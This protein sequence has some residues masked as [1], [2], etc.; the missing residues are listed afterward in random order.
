[1]RSG[2]AFRDIPEGFSLTE[3]ENFN[4][5]IRQVLRK[6]QNTIQQ[7]NGNYKKYGPVFQCFIQGFH[8]VW[9]FYVIVGVH[10]GSVVTAY[11]HKGRTVDTPCP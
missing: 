1:M 6:P 5:S 3:G 9:T 4:F 2:T 10:S 8:I 11:G 7:E